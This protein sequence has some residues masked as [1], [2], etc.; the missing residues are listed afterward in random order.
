MTAVDFTP[1]ALARLAARGYTTTVLD[2]LRRGEHDIA[3]AL[4]ASTIQAS[5]PHTCDE[6]AAG[7]LA[8]ITRIGCQGCADCMAAEFGDHPDQAAARMRWALAAEAR[9]AHDHALA[10]G[11]A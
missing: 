1:E 7:A 10:G 2:D 4:F 3:E 5:E 6:L 8:V 11:G 9:L